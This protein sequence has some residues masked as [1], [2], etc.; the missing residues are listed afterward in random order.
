MGERKDQHEVLNVRPLS[1]RLGLT[2]RGD[3]LREPKFLVKHRIPATKH[4]ELD[5]QCTH[6]APLFKQGSVLL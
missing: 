3:W 2:A 5:G 6:M 4:V 1:H